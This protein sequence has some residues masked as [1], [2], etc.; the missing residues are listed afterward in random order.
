MIIKEAKYIST[1]CFLFHENFLHTLLYSLSL[2]IKYIIHNI[3][4]YLRDINNNQLPLHSVSWAEPN[5]QMAL[6]YNI[7][8]FLSQWLLSSVTYL[9]LNYIYI[10]I[11]ISIV[12]PPLI[13][14]LPF[15]SHLKIKVKAPPKQ[16]LNHFI[17]QNMA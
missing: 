1:Y 10:C 6:R 3:Y 12:S 11:C 5:L 14:V 2:Y 9:Y 4:I 16:K 17:L 7:Y 13:Y 8:L 15:I